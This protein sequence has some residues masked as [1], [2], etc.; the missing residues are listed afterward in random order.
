MSDDEILDATWRALCTHGYAELT[1]QDIADETDKSKAALHYHYDS[2]RDLLVAFL[3][4]VSDRFLTRV[5]EAEAAAGEDP[6][7]RLSAVV[8]AALS[9]PNTDDIEDMQTALLELKAQA[10][11]VDPFR[12]RIERADRE[13]RALLADIVADGVADGSFRAAVDP[14]ETAHFVV[15]MFGGAQLR[16]VS[17]G[18]DRQR[19]RTHIQRHLERHVYAGEADR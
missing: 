19:I 17:V 15:A 11:H 9:P 12:E 2:K 14:E 7:A 16:Q 5:R 18:E 1:M 6:T 8:D 4:H 13:F 10:P 3:D